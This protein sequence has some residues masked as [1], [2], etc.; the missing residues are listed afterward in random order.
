MEEERNCHLYE[1]LG[2]YSTF[3]GKPTGSLT[4]V[5]YTHLD[6]YKRQP[7]LR[8]AI[9][10]IPLPGI[11]KNRSFMTTCSQERKSDAAGRWEEWWK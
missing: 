10:L 9:P 5:S 7:S 11:P 3:T 6:V 4:P 8:L 2:F 1:K